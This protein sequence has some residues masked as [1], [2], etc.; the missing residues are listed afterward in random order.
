MYFPIYNI[1]MYVYYTYVYTHLAYVHVVKMEH[2]IICIHACKLSHY[3]THPHYSLLCVYMYVRIRMLKL[4]TGV[5]NKTIYTANMCIVQYNI[6]YAIEKCSPTYFLPCFHTINPNNETCL[7]TCAVSLTCA[8]WLMY[9]MHSYQPGYEYKCICNKWCMC[10]YLTLAPPHTS[11]TTFLFMSSRR[12][13][14]STPVTLTLYRRRS[15]RLQRQPRVC[16][17]GCTLWTSMTSECVYV[18]MYICT[19]VWQLLW[20]VLLCIYGPT[21]MQT[22]AGRMNWFWFQ[23]QLLFKLKVNLLITGSN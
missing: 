2:C 15:K 12:S 11:R 21:C 3:S 10:S 8:T 1:R 20:S 9:C 7:V 17:S 14:T 6:L 19:C 13:E 16:A 18:H 23:I 22:G 5:E 4:C